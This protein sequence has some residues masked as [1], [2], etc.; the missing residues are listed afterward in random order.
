MR[1]T[2]LLEGREP[3]SRPLAEQCIFMEARVTYWA[4][5]GAHLR[6]LVDGDLPL[7]EMHLLNLD[8]PSRNSRFHCG[9][10]DTAVT[11]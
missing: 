11:N 7:I 10:V 4:Q 8:M 1:G 6:R 5:G 9:F 2:S 3:Q